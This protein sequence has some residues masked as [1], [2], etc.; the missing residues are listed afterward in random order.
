M[1]SKVVALMSCSILQASSA[2]ISFGTPI[3]SKSFESSSV[4]KI[5]SETADFRWE[6]ANKDSKVANFT[7]RSYMIMRSFYRSKIINPNLMLYIEGF[8]TWIY[9]GRSKFFFN[10]QKLIVFCNTFGTTWC[11]SL[12]LIC[13]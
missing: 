13:I 2:A 4:K 6:C 1:H 8:W 11:T 3:F 12:N 10:A 7:V 5:P 9:S